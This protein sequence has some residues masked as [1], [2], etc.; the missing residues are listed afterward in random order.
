MPI[1]TIVNPDDLR[2][3]AHIE[4]TNGL[5]EVQPGQRVKFTVDAFDP[6]EYSGTVDEIARTSDESS[7]AFNI[8]DKREVKQFIVKIKYD[9]A[10]YPELL[11]GMSARVWIYKE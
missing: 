7:I 10:T 3:V 11:N 8:S 2:V 5:S 1:I 6:K 9:V 4:E